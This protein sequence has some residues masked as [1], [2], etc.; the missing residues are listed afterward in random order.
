LLENY[1]TKVPKE[2][3]ILAI[4]EIL[5]G[6]IDNSA[7]LF[8]SKVSKKILEEREPLNYLHPYRRNLASHTEAT[9]ESIP[10]LWDKL[11][12]KE[13]DLNIHSLADLKIK[14]VK[15]VIKVLNS[16]KAITL[17]KQIIKVEL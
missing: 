11:E 9:L 2:L 14:I 1:Y 5:N 17:D 10:N 16:T 13:K 7:Q 15:T 12:F 6:Y 4:Y 3:K 8:T